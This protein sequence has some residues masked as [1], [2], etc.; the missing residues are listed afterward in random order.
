MKKNIDILLS[1][2][3]N[4]GDMGF[5][6]ELMYGLAWVYPDIFHYT[7]W[8]DD[9]AEVSRFFE[10]NKHLMPTYQIEPIEQFWSVELSSFCFSLF[11]GF[12]PKKERFTIPACILRIDYISLDLGW[13]QNHR[14]EHIDSSSDRQIIEIIPSPLLFGWGIFH[15]S[16][17]S[18]SRSR[19][20]HTYHLDEYKK[21]I[22]LFCYEQTFHNCIDLTHI[23][24]DREV[25]ILW[26]RWGEM[27]REQ[28]GWKNIHFLSFL[29]LEE[30]HHVLAYSQWSII[31]G[32][33]SL[34]NI[35]SL[36]KPFFWDMYKMIGGLNTQQSLD[37]LE[38]R[39]ASPEY[40]R[41]HMRLNAQIPWK[42]TLNECESILFDLDSQKKSL[43]YSG[44]HLIHEV[45][46]Y[47]DSFY[48]SL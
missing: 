1:V 37:F 13:L 34:M 7:L 25:L 40:Q 45:K 42:I 26:S 31:R 21:W 15:C 32:E 47:I 41:L 6:C 12:L 24:E 8:T 46:K 38:Y 48:F 30:F 5:A 3:D 20:A 39:E 4:Y 2:V 14:V 44:K 11:H 22:T 35:L 43:R 33:I 23:P 36:E 27:D 29:N 28:W 17:P 16:A 19:I 9:I 10:K 18:Y